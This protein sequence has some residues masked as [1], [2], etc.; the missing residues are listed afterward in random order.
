MER[1]TIEQAI[2][3]EYNEA[4]HNAYFANGF[5]RG[6]KWQAE[7]SYSDEMLEIL[8]SFIEDFD[9]GLIEDF[10]IPRDRFEQLLKKIT[11]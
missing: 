4:G 8:K 2:D 6:V 9:K 3:R 11:Q 1:E 10:K 7:K 5:K